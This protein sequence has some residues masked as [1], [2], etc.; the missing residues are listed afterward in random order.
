M[1]CR[2]FLRPWQNPLA[3]YRGLSSAV[4]FLST[5]PSGDSLRVDSQNAAPEW[6]AIS[7]QDDIADMMVRDTTPAPSSRARLLD[8]W[9][10]TMSMVCFQSC[11]R[12]QPAPR[13]GGAQ[14]LTSQPTVQLQRGSDSGRRWR[15]GD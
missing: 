13:G 1:N 2:A 10:A 14:T 6:Y 11:G 5:T 9:Q 7:R 4:V 8:A 12:S 15:G 3:S